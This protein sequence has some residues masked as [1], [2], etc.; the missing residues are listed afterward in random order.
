MP[1]TDIHPK[2]FPS[3]QVSCACGN[4]FNVG[5]TQQEIAVEICSNCHPFYTGEKKLLDVA[6]RVERFKSRTAKKASEP[7]TKKVR[8][9]K[10]AP[11]INK[12]K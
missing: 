4:S 8:A 10:Q 7:K 11:A 12:E 1:K 3:A 6:G 5:A 2:Y 9:K